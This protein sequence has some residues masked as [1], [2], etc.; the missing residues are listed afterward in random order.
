MTFKVVIK[1]DELPPV[2]AESGEHTIRF[3][4][5]SADRNRTSAWV[6]TN[7]QVPIS[8]ATIPHS[9]ST[10]G[11]AGSK[12]IQVAWTYAEGMK[13]EYDVYAQY[14]GGKWEYQGRTNSLSHSW[15]QK[16]G[17]KKVKV[18][19]QHPTYP[20]VCT[21]AQALFTTKETSLV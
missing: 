1:K 17:S 21:P 2:S 12:V 4:I 5:V 20:T 3:R 14:D 11:A 16:A 7:L 13:H 10:T 9:I 18:A 19:V 8:R 15:L 6:Q